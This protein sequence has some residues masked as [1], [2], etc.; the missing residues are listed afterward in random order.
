[1]PPPL[2]SP[3]DSLIT[4]P[5]GVTRVY[6]LYLSSGIFTQSYC[7]SSS[8]VS[9][10]R[11]ETGSYVSLSSHY[12]QHC[13]LYTIGTQGMEWKMFIVSS[14]CKASWPSIL[15]SGQPLAHPPSLQHPSISA[16]SLQQDIRRWLGI[17]SRT[18][19][20]IGRSWLLWVSVPTYCCNSRLH[21]FGNPLSEIIFKRKFIPLGIKLG[22]VYGPY[23]A[24]DE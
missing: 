1:M 21:C 20:L 3:L 5:S 15:I 8:S 24:T 12:L 19:V 22:C 10:W 11:V 7:I 23:F 2:I 18:T 13:A 16:A 9:P 6:Y 14:S 17:L 4:L